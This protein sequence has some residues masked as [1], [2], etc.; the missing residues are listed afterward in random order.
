MDFLT[1]IAQKL[2]ALP[3]I[4][5]WPALQNIIIANTSRPHLDWELPWYVSRS[6]GNE[7]EDSIVIGGAALACMQ[8]SI[9][10]VDDVLDNDPKGIHNQ[11]GTGPT[12]N[13]A[14]ALQ[15]ASFSL[16]ADAPLTPQTRVAAISH[17]ALMGQETAFGQQVDI[18]AQDLTEDN[19][20]SLVQAKSVPFYKSAFELGGIL[21]GVDEKRKAI[22][23]ELGASLG[24]MIQIHDDMGDALAVPAN[25]DWGQNRLNLLLIYA[26]VVD[27][28][29]KQRFIQLRQKVADPA[30]LAEAQSIL[31][32]SGAASFAVY[33]LAQRNMWTQDRIRALNHLSAQQKVTFD[34]SPLTYVFNLHIKPVITLLER[35]HIPLPD[36]LKSSANE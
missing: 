12:S 20:W 26:T 35:H 21:S 2:L 4:G 34:P 23:G 29:Q 22:L 36:V 9:I 27:Y 8:M 18:S 30:S 17:L 31:I 1:Q 6:L 10:L 15:A 19:Y 33:Q 11:I 24:E 25:P 32:Q 7:A 16:L 13:M 5:Q 28:P 14:L 3:I